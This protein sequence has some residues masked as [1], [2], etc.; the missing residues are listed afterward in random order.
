MTDAFSSTF[1][2]CPE[3]NHD[4]VKNGKVRGVQRFRCVQCKFN[5]VVQVKNRFNRSYKY[6]QVVRRT[7]GWDLL[8]GASLATVDRWVL[9]AQEH[10]PW[11][12]RRIAEIGEQATHYSEHSKT[13][14]P[15][16]R[17]HLGKIALD[18]MFEAYALALRRDAFVHLTL[19]AFNQI[20]DRMCQDGWHSL[21]AAL[22]EYLSS[23]HNNTPWIIKEAPEIVA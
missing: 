16:H 22:N 18:A 8:D 6:D 21:A 13:T 23:E 11:F 7:S 10:H 1:V 4:C 17:G 15:S 2:R 3:C 9:E 14:R 12:L 5:F 19:D 20:F